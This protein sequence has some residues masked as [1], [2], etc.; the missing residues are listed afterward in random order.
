M[1]KA[2][3]KPVLRPAATSKKRNIASFKAETDP[4]VILP[5]KLRAALDRLKKDG[6]AEAYAYEFT[7][8]TGSPTMCGMS[9]ISAA[10][11][12]HYRHQFADHIVLAKQ[13]T[14][15]R[16]GPKFVWFATPK[17]ATE[18]RGGPVDM[19]IFDE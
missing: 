1:A 6:G 17:A 3:V 15:S 11:I 2:N 7:D 14:G 19:S 10:H 16:R 12:N 18:A 4:T 9:G 13:D 8:K 5:N